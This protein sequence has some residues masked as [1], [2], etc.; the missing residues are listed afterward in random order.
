LEWLIILL[1]LVAWQVF[2]NHRSQ[3]CTYFGS[4]VHEL[5][6]KKDMTIFFI[7][8]NGDFHLLENIKMVFY[9]WLKVKFAHITF[10]IIVGGLTILFVWAL[11]NICYIVL[12]RLLLS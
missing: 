7:I 4:L 8:K 9:W 6:E 5:F 10:N 2:Q 11:V 12:L 3:L 1:N